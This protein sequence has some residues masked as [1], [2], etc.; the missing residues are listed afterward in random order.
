MAAGGPD[1]FYRGEIG[2][3]VAGHVQGLGGLLDAGDL[4]AHQGEWVEPLEGRYRDLTVA[5][6]PPN[7]QGRRPC[8][9]CICST[10]PGRCH[11]TARSA[12]TG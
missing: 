8:W 3:A 6:L 11:P 12:S 1:A 7:S 5:E 10:R 4:A 9:P 2:A